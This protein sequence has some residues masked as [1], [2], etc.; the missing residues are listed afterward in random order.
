MSTR[1][2]SARPA[3]AMRWA[4]VAPTFP[5]PM[6]VTLL[7]GMRVSFLHSDGSI[8]GSGRDV[9]GRVG[10]TH[11]DGR[12]RGVAVT[13]RADA[14]PREA[15]QTMTQLAALIGIVLI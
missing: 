1:T 6:T 10:W 2:T 9:R 5:A 13:M 4:V 14:Q 8:L 15:R 12:S 7:R 11:V 3:S